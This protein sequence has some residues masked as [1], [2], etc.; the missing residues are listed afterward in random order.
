LFFAVPAG[1]DARTRLDARVD[2]LTA[3]QLLAQNPA[4]LVDAGRQRR[5]RNIADIHHAASA[6]WGLVQILAFWWLWRSGA[7]ARIRDMMRRRTRSRTAQRAVFGA[8]LGAL[9]PIV[10]L[11]FGL[12]SYRVGFNAGVTDERLPQWF[13]DYLVRIGLDAL[14]GALVVVAVLALVDRVR[15]W[16]LVLM[17]LFYAGALA[18]VTLAPV[19]PFGTAQKTTPNAVAALGAEM[20]RALGVPGTPVVVLASSRHSNAMSGRAAGIGPTARALIGDVTLVHLTPPELR[21]AFAHA[22]AHVAYNDK[23]RQT[24]V[25]VTLFV[26]SAAIAVL[27][28]DRVG[29][30]RDDDA[31][32]RLALVGTFLGC[33]LVVAYPI[34]NADARNVESRADRVALSA[35]GDRAETV[36]TMVRWADDDLVPLCD[37]RSIRWYFDDRPPLG[38][39]IAKTA[40]SADPC[41][42]GGPA[43]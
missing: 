42:G 5:A 11:P 43:L 27:L 14:L 1:S 10:S 29:F 16:Y 19:M 40:G 24:L 12:I 4:T 3:H 17:A 38:G 2:M 33:V 30:R 7:A 9:G 26:L 20:A 8:V 31:L 18:G 6:G 15:V 36:R 23:L 35:T 37:R 28:S 39:R 22:F 32:S 34:Y 41:P 25:A 13:L 21:V